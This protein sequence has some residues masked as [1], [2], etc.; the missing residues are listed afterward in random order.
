M[1]IKFSTVKERKAPSIYLDSEKLKRYQLDEFEY[2]LTQAMIDL[3]VSMFKE[4]E[5]LMFSKFTDKKN[6]KNLK[7]TNG[8]IDE[9][10]L[11]TALSKEDINL[12][13]TV[14][15][16]FA[17]EAIKLIPDLDLEELKEHFL[18]FK[19]G[20]EKTYFDD[21]I[22]DVKDAINRA[23]NELNNDRGKN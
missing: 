18:K 13:R 15:D 6:M 16:R 20:I 21:F 1:G 2:P 23:V 22:D 7:M 17:A 5:N 9:M 3:K 4:A 8:V 11:L 14:D 19:D 10:T 12:T